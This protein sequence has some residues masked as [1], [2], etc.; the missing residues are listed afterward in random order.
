MRYHL[1]ISRYNRSE[2]K[3]SSG[4][5]LHQMHNKRSLEVHVVHNCKLN[6]DIAL[7]VYKHHACIDK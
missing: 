2:Q 4:K 6:Y 1:D 7:G 3:R 5:Y